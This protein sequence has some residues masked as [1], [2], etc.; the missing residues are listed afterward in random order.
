MIL[1]CANTSG[2]LTS[3]KKKKKE[4]RIQKAEDLKT[5]ARLVIL[6][7]D[8]LSTVAGLYPEGVLWW[9]LSI[10]TANWHSQ[11]G[12]GEARNRWKQKKALNQSERV[13]GKRAVTN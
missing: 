7:I 9:E 8:N 2:N 11:T 12:D 13:K 1:M 4:K 6:G 10:L 3:G 5:S